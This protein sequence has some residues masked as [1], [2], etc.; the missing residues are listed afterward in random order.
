[1]REGNSRKAGLLG[2]ENKMA[3]FLE[4]LKLNLKK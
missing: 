4:I 1:L 3:E 2:G